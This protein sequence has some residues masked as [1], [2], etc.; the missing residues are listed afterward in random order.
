MFAH[1]LAGFLATSAA[2]GRI[3]IDGPLADRLRRRLEE[4]ATQAVRLEG[5]LLRLAPLVAAFPVVVL[6]GPVLAHG[7][8]PDPLLRPF[9]DLD[10]LIPGSRLEEFV[11]AL[12]GL[13]Y[14]RARPEPAPGY[15][16]RVGKAVTLTHPGGVVIDL[17][18]TL[19]AGVV[20]ASIDVDAIVADHISVP[21]GSM[22]V[23]APSWEAHLIECALHAV[24]GDGLARALS[25]RDVA[26]VALDSRLDVDAAIALASRWQVSDA[27]ADGLRASMD[28]LGLAPPGGLAAIASDAIDAD[29]ALPASVRSARSRL[30]RA[31]PR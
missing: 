13:G 12:A 5:E 3:D 11:V 26:Q 2:A 22:D 23:P 21:V 24:V 14:E 25:L 10:L 29:S 1:G 8:Y 18:R 4:E 15:D 6:K 19:V 30:D 28:G 9:T 31:P 16:A 27:L 7:A 17:H 20:G